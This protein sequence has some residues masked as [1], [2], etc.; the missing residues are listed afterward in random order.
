[1]S[2]EQVADQHA[3][4]GNKATMS[5]TCAETEEDKVKELL[6]VMNAASDMDYIGEAI[7]Q[8]E[9]GLQCAKFAAD[10]GKQCTSAVCVMHT[11]SLAFLH[12]RC[13]CALTLIP[14]SSG[15]CEDVI[16]ASLFHDIGHF[17]VQHPKAAARM[18]IKDPVSCMGEV[19][20]QN[21]E[22]LGALY[23]SLLGFSDKTAEL[24]RKHV[25]AKVPRNV[26]FL[27]SP[28]DDVRVTC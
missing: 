19:G 9:H 13:T 25:L 4:W 12:N 21:H 6:E 11:G 20:V 15:A 26:V 28:S 22:G 2:C 24:V 17:C 18:R 8:L 10:A 5:C 27:I 14:L 3:W 1:M 16:L 7:S 23:L